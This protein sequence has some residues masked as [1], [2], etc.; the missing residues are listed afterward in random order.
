MDR[1]L[2][3]GAERAL[4]VGALLGLVVLV[5]AVLGP[6]F[7]ARPVFFRS[8]SMAPSIE[9]GSL[10]LVRRVPATD[11]RA[12]DVVTVTTRSGTRVTH[13]IVGIE[14]S[15]SGHVVLT[16]RGDANRSVDAERYLVG[17]A[18]RVFWHVPRLGY[19]ASALSTTPTLLAFGLTLAG[20]LAARGPSGS[21]SAGRPRHVRRRHRARRVGATGAATIAV[22]AGPTGPA[23]AVPWTNGVDIGGT[24]L[25]ARTV[26]APT[27]SCGT[28]IVGSTTL[29]WTAVPGATGYTLHYGAGGTTTETIGAGVTSKTFS[30]VAT[31]GD[32]SVNATVDYGSTTW[33]SAASNVKHY[34]VVLFLVGVCTDA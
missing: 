14:P 8:G 15:S 4:T 12:G 1:V 27:V 30:G 18:Y 23:S 25:T 31:S 20:L 16:L 19:A 13:R 11:L 17:S 26:P 29:S 28:L 5:G 9:T 34:T 33:T 7:G 22:I 6:T 21:P 10:A 32:F 24:T 3:R 2:R